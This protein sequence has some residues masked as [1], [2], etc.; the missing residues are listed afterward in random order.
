MSTN[1]ASGK[2]LMKRPS[3]PKE[4]Q[5]EKGVSGN[6]NG[7]PRKSGGTVPGAANDARPKAFGDTFMSLALQEQQRPM[8]LKEGERSELV[9][10]SQAVMRRLG[11][12]AVKGVSKAQQMYLKIAADMEGPVT[13]QKVAA[14][15]W[16][17]NYVDEWTLRLI[18]EVR[19]GKPSSEP[20]PHPDDFAFDFG[21]LEFTVDGPTTRRQ[22]LYQDALIADLP[23][24]LKNLSKLEE[25]LA[26][27]RKNKQL[28][29]DVRKQNEIIDWCLQE[30]GKR[31]IRRMTY[32][33]LA[34]VTPR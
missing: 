22:R 8:S 31:N 10:T 3:P 25:L 26:A 5:F 21:T 24:L 9:P 2:A 27:D 15:T 6:L 13:A 11:V 34:K 1:D 32:E 18:E 19:A 29:E 30:M 4:F 16:A 23:E 7:R 28:R 20:V 12:D 17:V 14:F 33:K